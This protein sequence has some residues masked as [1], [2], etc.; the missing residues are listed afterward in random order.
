VPRTEY[1]NDP[2]APCPNRIVVAAT[3]F[4][5]T[6]VDPTGRAGRLLMIQRSDT[7][8]WAL[9]GG[10]LDLGERIAET[11][12]RETREE[13][14]VEIHITGLVGVYSNPR[15]VISYGV[16]DVRQQFSLCFRGIPV[17]GE[18]TPSFESL[19]VR[20]VDVAELE[21]LDIHPEMRLRI[22]HGVANRDLPHIG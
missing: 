14:G 4:V 5:V 21:R 16:R 22:E 10:I 17:G 13:T 2:T 12:V 8:R 11:A 20:W 3:A 1:L 19:D 18:P 9:P 15:H 7:G 6:N